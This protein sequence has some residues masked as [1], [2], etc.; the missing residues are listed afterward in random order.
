VA[1]ECRQT[2]ASG[3]A[4]MVCVS[5]AVVLPCPPNGLRPA[6]RCPS[7][8]VVPGFQVR[9]CNKM[10][11]KCPVRLPVCVCAAAADGQPASSVWQVRDNA[12]V[13]EVILGG[14]ANALRASAPVMPGPA[15]ALSRTHVQGV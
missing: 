8:E 6:L 14:R 3:S 7:E 4:E 15:A 1:G 11:T 10:L 5:A 12:Q 13:S 9:V 2:A